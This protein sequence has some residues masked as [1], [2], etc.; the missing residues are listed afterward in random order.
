MK[1]AIN[2]SPLKTGHK[3]RGIGFYTRNLITSLKDLGVEVEE[4]TD[5]REVKDV[6]V[7]H[8]PFLDL[9]YRSLSLKNKFPTV[10]TIHDVTPLVFPQH[11]PPGIKGSLNNFWQKLALKD[12]KAVITDSQA[13]KKDI[14]KYLNINLKK[15]YPVYLAQE[16]RFHLIK[17][18]TKLSLV[19]KKYNLPANFALYVGSVNWNK[20]L[21]NLTQACI[22]TETD[23]VLV[24]RD[25][26]NRD[27]LEHPERKSYGQFLAKYAQHRKVHIQGFINDDDLVEIM[28]LS[29]VALLPSFY[30]G[31]G[32][33]I[34]ESQACGIPIITSN[35]SSMPEVAGDGALFVNPY[36][37]A[38]ISGGLETIM[39]NSS[40]REEIIKKG[41]ENVKRFSWEKT[42]KE[43][44]NIYCKILKI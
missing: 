26:E 6:D 41:F 10:V 21:L 34:L 8:Y 38:D 36:N 18:K 15:I 33:P 32:L 16:E 44:V 1:I 43:T 39:N 29:K 25:F 3:V 30:E 31:F 23:L 42:A 20:N 24:G 9:F 35:I 7:V 19:S 13:S 40:K 37:V 27:N 17:D 4:F 11:Y 12:I 22:N 28:N 14:S 5:I 2:S